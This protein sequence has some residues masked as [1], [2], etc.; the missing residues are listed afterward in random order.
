M[1]LTD[2][3]FLLWRRKYS[4]GVSSNEKVEIGNLKSAIMTRNL[5]QFY[6]TQNSS[7]GASA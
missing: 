7:F 6:S 3:V 5:T 1:E 4:L 2:L